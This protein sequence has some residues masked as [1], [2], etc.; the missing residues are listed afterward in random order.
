MQQD[1]KEMGIDDIAYRLGEW[2]LSC[3]DRHNGKFEPIWQEYRRAA[4]D[5][6]EDCPMR[7]LTFV[8]D[9]LDTMRTK[10]NNVIHECE[11]LKQKAMEDFDNGKV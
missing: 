9:L 3:A 8:W 4:A 10:L 5:P 1:I 6:A 11:C 2:L 7:E